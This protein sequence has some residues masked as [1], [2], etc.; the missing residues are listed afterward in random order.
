MRKAASVLAFAAL[1]LYAGAAGAVLYKWVDAQGRVQ[2][3][4]QL[5]KGFK[6]EV[7]RIEADVR[8]TPS[9]IAPAATPAPRAAQGS[10]AVKEEP[11]ADIATKRR[12]TREALDARVAKARVAVESARKALDEAGGPE[13]DERQ[14][15]QQQ[16]QAGQG[17]MHG[18]SQARSTC[19]TAKDASGNNIVLCNAMVPNDQYFERMTKLELALKAAEE[20][21][22]E[23]QEARRRGID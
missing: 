17:G 11:I 2:Y 23:A 6:G 19:R 15:I 18:Q 9:P 8:A 5:P 10:D 13:P 4:D 1:G 22:A 7:T 12:T 21:L 14:V 20:E 16:Q 3:S